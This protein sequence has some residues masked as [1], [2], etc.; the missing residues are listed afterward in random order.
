MK[1]YDFLEEIIMLSYKKI[2]ACSLLNFLVILYR[3]IDALIADKI[4]VFGAMII[5]LKPEL[6]ELTD[7]K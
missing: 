6:S 3:N 1:S 5:L 7:I 4:T 2:D